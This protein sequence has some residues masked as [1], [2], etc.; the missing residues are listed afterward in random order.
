MKEEI[1]RYVALIKNLFVAFSAVV[2]PAI[3]VCLV[4]A[5]SRA[6][7]FY[8]ITPVLALFYFVVYGVYALY[9]SMGTVTGMQ[10]SGDTVTLVTR[11][12]RF[13]YDAESGCVEVKTYPRKFVAT[14]ET[15]NSRDKFIFY[16]RAPFSSNYQEQFTLAEMRL[17][18]PG[19]QEYERR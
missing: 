3:M 17:V 11:R 5:F 13:S 15:E 6:A 12:K 10:I 9:V 2:L 1:V 14:F 19:A 4:F 16:R 7:A 8:I 18:F